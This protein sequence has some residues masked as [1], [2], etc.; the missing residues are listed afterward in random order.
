VTHFETFQERCSA[1]A[2]RAKAAIDEKN[3]LSLQIATLSDQM[4]AAAFQ[5]STEKRMMQDQVRTA[6]S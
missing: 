3:A 1:A 6:A 5:S 2:D 4:A